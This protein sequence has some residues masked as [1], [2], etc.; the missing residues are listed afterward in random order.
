MCRLV[1]DVAFPEIVHFLRGKFPT[2]A[3]LEDISV[4]FEDFVSEQWDKIV[5][6]AMFSISNPTLIELFT[7]HPTAH[8]FHM[9]KPVIEAI[10]TFEPIFS[11]KITTVKKAKN[12]SETDTL[13]AEVKKENRRL[14][15]TL[16]QET[17]AIEGQKER[18]I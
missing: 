16:R 14:K 1:P 15:K 10:P 5:P 4:T 11:D 18:E 7:G 8:T 2:L 9:R 17:A 13:K 3:A 12:R 6:S